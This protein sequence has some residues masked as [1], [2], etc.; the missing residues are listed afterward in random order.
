MGS[1]GA[2]R[3]ADEVLRSL[4]TRIV[5]HGVRIDVRLAVL[6]L[7]SSEDDEELREELERLVSSAERAESAFLDRIRGA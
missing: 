4:R 7:A 5:E 2:K 6:E 1:K 3:G